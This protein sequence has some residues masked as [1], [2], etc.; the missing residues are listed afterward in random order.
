MERGEGEGKWR[1]IVGKGKQEAKF[2]GRVSFFRR[3]AQDKIVHLITLLKDP[4]TSEPSPKGD[5]AEDSAFRAREILGSILHRVVPE[6]L[7]TRLPEGPIA[8]S[9]VFRF[10]LLHQLTIRRASFVLTVSMLL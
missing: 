9:G 10:S 4:P 7:G 3:W 2:G 5:K 8:T 6:G 1:K